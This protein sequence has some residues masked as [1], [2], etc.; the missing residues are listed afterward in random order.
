MLGSQDRVQISWTGISTWMLRTETWA[1]CKKTGAP[2]QGA[3]SLAPVDRFKLDLGD[4]A[5]EQLHN[6]FILW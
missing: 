3:I 6:V 4:K 2:Y 1:L 5:K